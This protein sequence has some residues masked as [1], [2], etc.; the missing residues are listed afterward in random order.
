MSKQPKTV[1]DRMREDHPETFVP[2]YALGQRIMEII[3]TNQEKLK[4]VQVTDGL[5]IAFLY[6]ELTREIET[7]IKEEIKP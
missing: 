2:G 5:A 6:G 4:D 1:R 7:A 3:K